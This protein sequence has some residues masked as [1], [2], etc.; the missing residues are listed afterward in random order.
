[1]DSTR[2]AVQVSVCRLNP[3]SSDVLPSARRPAMVAGFPTWLNNSVTPVHIRR[4]KDVV[5]DHIFRS[6]HRP[7]TGLYARLRFR[8]P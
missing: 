7:H 4:F 6:F 2:P 1:M 8:F 3:L 5:D